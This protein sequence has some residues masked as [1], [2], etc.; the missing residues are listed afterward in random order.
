MLPNKCF[1]RGVQQPTSPTIS[2]YLRLNVDVLLSQS[3]EDRSVSGTGG[4]F[5]ETIPAVLS[6]PST[7]VIG[8]NCHWQLWWRQAN[9]QRELLI[10]S[11]YQASSI[12][13]HG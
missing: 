4:Y 12:F 13:I 9:R 6:Q 5:G 11:Q 7:I 3:T 10:K 1:G 2:A 8:H